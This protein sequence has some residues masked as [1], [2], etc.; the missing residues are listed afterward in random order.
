MTYTIVIIIILHYKTMCK[1]L[2]LHV[3]SILMFISVD[4]YYYKVGHVNVYNLCI[5]CIINTHN[6]DIVN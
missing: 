4:N 6:D 2:A 3:I 1:M 5:M